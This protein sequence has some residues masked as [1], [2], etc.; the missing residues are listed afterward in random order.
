MVR[1]PVVR[2]AGTLRSVNL[3]RMMLNSAAALA[4]IPL[5]LSIL[6]LRPQN[7]SRVLPLSERRATPAASCRNLAIIRRGV[8]RRPATPPPPGL[9]DLPSTAGP[10]ARGL[11]EELIDEFRRW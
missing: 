11:G 3:P 6:L 1:G 8:R 5:Y 4:A 9:P 10:S 2:H 7:V